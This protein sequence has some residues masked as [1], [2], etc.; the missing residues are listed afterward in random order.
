MTMDARRVS[1]GDLVAALQGDGG[2]STDH[3]VRVE[4]QVP[5]YKAAGVVAAIE[6]D[7]V[8]RNEVMTEMAAVL[9]DGSGILVIEG[10]I[11][12]PVID[13]AS[14]VFEAIIAEERA[15]GRGGGDHFAKPGANDRIWNALEKHCLRWPESFAEYY[16]DPAIALVA[17]AWLGPG[18]QVTAQVNVVNPGGEAQQP[19]RDYHLGFMTDDQASRF[20]HHVHLLSPVLTLQGAVAHCDMPVETGPTMYLPRSQRYELGYL[21][22]RDPAI[23]AYFAENHVQLALSKGDLVFF[24]PALFH[25]AGANSTSSVR[26]MANLLQISSP[27]GRAMERIDRRTMIDALYPVLGRRLAAGV[28]RG[29]VARAVA[30]CAD[31]YAFPADLDREQPVDGLTPDADAVIVNRGLDEHWSMERLRKVLSDRA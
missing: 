26:R 25:A 20:P 22:W 13:G 3:A 6:A 14:E 9:L 11:D 8:G 5:I 10:A 4:R 21:A 31:G 15:T 29:S 24:N 1:V 7:V 30:A 23:R 2:V 27:L 12:G 16:A 28:E 19:H 17:E 18:Y